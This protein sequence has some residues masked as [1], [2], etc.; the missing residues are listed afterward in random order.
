MRRY[1]PH[2]G[3]AAARA[4]EWAGKAYQ[5]G[6]CLRW[7]LYE[8]LGVAPTALDAT[9]YWAEAVERGDV[10]KARSPRSSSVIPPGSLVLWTGGPH[11]HAAIMLDDGKIATTDLPVRSRVGVVP[12]EAIHDQ[13][14]YELAGYVLVDGSGWILT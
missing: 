13:W 6:W 8:V 1:A 9:T 5:R 12:I 7:A 4:A 3:A 14:G 10:V 11:G 2:R